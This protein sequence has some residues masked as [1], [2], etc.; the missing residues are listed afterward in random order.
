MINFKKNFSSINNYINERIEEQFYLDE[1][2][3][4]DNYFTLNE[5]NNIINEFKKLVISTVD[6]IEKENDLYSM[7]INETIN[8]FIKDNKEYLNK[9]IS[10]INIIF[11]DEILEKISLSFENAFESTLNKI[12]EDLQ[13]NE[14]LSKNYF[15]EL[16]DI[17]NSKE[18]SL[19]ILSTTCNENITS[20]EMVPSCEINNRR[21]CYFKA[22]CDDSIINL[23]KTNSYI[24]NY[25]SYQEHMNNS[26]VYIREIFNKEIYNE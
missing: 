21:N 7:K 25:Y 24:K 23:T 17:V 3:L 22:F 10:E 20:F 4:K 8:L 11:S 16:F 26:N 6:K 15:N 5:Q 2:S 18:N 14:L 12:K 1:N 19:K 9:L 13:Y